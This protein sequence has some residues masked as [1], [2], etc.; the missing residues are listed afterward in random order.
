MVS[1]L[2][3]V[4]MVLQ[5]LAGFLL[6]LALLIVLRRKYGCKVKAFLIG[7]IVMLVFALTLESAV[8]QVVLTSPVGVTIQQNIFLYAL[9]G[10]FMA[11]LFEETGRYLSMRFLMK[12]M[13]SNDMNAV[14]YGAGHGGFEAMVVLGITGIN[15]LVL[16]LAGPPVGPTNVPGL[17]EDMAAQIASYPTYMFLLGIVERV[18]A[19]CLH[20]ALSIFVWKAVTK[21]GAYRKYL[22]LAFLIHFA[23]DACTVILATYAGAVLLEIILLPICIALLYYAMK[24]V[25]Q[26]S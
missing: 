8:H 3:L 5:V 20:I 2:K 6:P 14:M 22:L 21:G 19:I 24:M 12:D 4:M 10:G 18:S 15:N 25:R 13:Y 1:G 7:A 23:V 9:Y 11:A 26:A 16:A 17:A